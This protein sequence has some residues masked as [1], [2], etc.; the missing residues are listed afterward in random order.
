M[1][2]ENLTGFSMGALGTYS[3]GVVVDNVHITATLAAG[4]KNFLLAAE[5]GSAPSLYVMN[6]SLKFTA[7]DTGAK[8]QIANSTFYTAYHTANTT[9]ELT[10]AEFAA[11]YDESVTTSSGKTYR[12]GYTIPDANGATSRKAFIYNATLKDTTGTKH[13]ITNEK[14]GTV[15]TE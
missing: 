1:N 14:T 10:N 4:Y 9:I 6:S 7:T 13:W 12:Y 2:V 11:D 15:V 5:N 3:Q 8:Y